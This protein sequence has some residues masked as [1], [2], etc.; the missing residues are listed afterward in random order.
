MLTL[1]RQ[2]A[3]G[4]TACVLFT[5]FAAHPARGAQ[6]HVVSPTEIHKVA[7]AATHTRQQNV[8][9]VTQFLSSPRA[10]QAL[11]S[12]HLSSTQVKNAVSNMS[13]E[14]VAQLASRVDKAQAEFAAGHMSDRDLILILLGIVVLILIIVAVR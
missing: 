2:S 3:L 14:E 5:L 7:V 11:Q 6:D 12:A 13:D 8:E 10:K 1:K 9:S 4:V